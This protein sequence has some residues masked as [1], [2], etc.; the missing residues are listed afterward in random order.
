MLGKH[1]K[2][3]VNFFNVIPIIILS[4]II[5]NVIWLTKNNIKNYI[6]FFI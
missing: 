1:R 3:F 6:L 4:T 2:N 5:V